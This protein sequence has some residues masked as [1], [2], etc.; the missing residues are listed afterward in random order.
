MN[1]HTS[2]T[3]IAAAP[4]NTPRRRRETPCYNQRSESPKRLAWA[5]CR[6]EWHARSLGGGGAAMH[7]RYPAGV[8]AAG[9]SLPR[10]GGFSGV[11][12]VASA[13]ASRS[14]L[15]GARSAGDR[16]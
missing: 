16:G 14:G 4:A 5:V 11:W 12:P 13:L 9:P 3:P 2:Y 6:D 1:E 7:R 10:T 8:E 15:N